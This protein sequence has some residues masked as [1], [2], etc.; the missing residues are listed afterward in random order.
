V[1]KAGGAYLPLDP[2]LPRERLLFMLADAGAPVVLTEKVSL[3]AGTAAEID[4]D[5]FDWLAPMEGRSAGSDCDLDS[6]SYVIYTSG[7]T[8]RPKG[9][10][11]PHRTL[12]NLI[13]WQIERLAGSGVD[14]CLRTLLFASPSFDVSLEETLAT[15]CTGA[16]LVVGPEEARR[17]PRLLVEVLEREGIERIFLPYVALQQLAEHLAGAEANL[18]ILARLREVV[19]AGERLQITPQIA[20]L[21]RRLPGCALRNQ[22][23]PSEAH[24][25]TEQSLLGDPAG[26]PLLPPIGRPIAGVTAYVLDRAGESS[27]LGVSGELALG[28]VSLARG[29]INRPDLTAEK[30]I[31]DPFSRSAGGRLYRTGDLARFQR[32]GEIE[33]LGRIDHQVKI[34]GFRIEPG[35]IEVALAAH[36]QVREAVVVV[37]GDGTAAGRRLVA[38][39]TPMAEE[40]ALAGADLRSFL[41]ERLPEYMLPAAFVVLSALPL[42]ASGKVQ[43]SALPAP[44]DSGGAAAPY[45]P[46]ATALERMVAEV[47]AEQLGAPRVGRDEN[48]FDAGAHSLLLVRVAAELARRLDRKVAVVDLFRFPTVSALARHLGEGA[49]D[50]AP[51]DRAVFER[52]AAERTAARREKR[53]QIRRDEM[54]NDPVMTATMK[55]SPVE[56][57]EPEEAFEQ[58]AV[59]G[60]ACRFPGAADPGELWRNVRDGVESITRLSDEELAA[61]GVPAELIDNPAYVKAGGFLADPD[62]FDADFFGFTPREAEL[63]DPQHRLFLECAWQACEDAGYVPQTYPGRIGVYGGS[64][65]GTYFVNNLLSNPE[66]LAAAGG[67]QVKLFNDKDFLTTHVSYKLNLRG[68]SLAIQTACSTSL[69]AVHVACQALLDGECDM[70]LAGGTGISFPHLAGHLYQEGGISSPDGHCRAFDIRAQGLVDGN[71]T[72]MVLLKRLSR[73]LA[74]GDF[75]HAVVRGSAIN[76]DGAQKAGYTVPSVDSQMEVIG[77]ALAAARVDA[78]TIGLVE[79]HGSGTPIGDPIEVQALTRAFRA[80]TDR[81]GFCALGSIKTNI[82]HT[83]AAAGVAGLIKAV[84]ALEHRQLPPSLHFEVPNPA[85][86]LPE[87]P[88]FVTSRALDWPAGSGQARRRAGVSSLGIGGTN[89]H[90][91]L[92]EAP[93]AALAAPSRPWQLLVVSARSKTA[94]DQAAA[95]LSNHLA[96]STVSRFELA[97]VAHTLRVG[98]KAFQHRRALLCRDRTGAVAAL[99]GSDPARWID[100]TAPVSG[101]RPVAF[102]FPGLGEHYAGMAA[103]LYRG[104]P[105]FRAAIDRSA[106]IL[107]PHLGADLRELLLYWEGGYPAFERAPGGAAAELNLRRMLA[108]EAEEEDEASRQLGRTAFAH[109]AVFA[110]EHALA[111][112]WLAWGIRPRAMIGYSLGEYV[113]AC[114][115]GVFSL[116]DAL[117]LVA[118][119]ARLIDALPAGAMLAVPLAVPETEALLAEEPGLALAAA[120][121]PGLSVVA[122]PEAAAAAFAQRLAGRGIACRRLRTGH[123]FHSPM[124]RPAAAELTR[125]AAGLDLRPPRI[126]FVSNVTGTWITDREATDPAY[127]AEHLCRPVRFASGLETLTADRVGDGDEAAQ[128]LLEVG[129]GQTLGTLAR[130]RPG[131]PAG[132]VVV[133]A[134]RDRREEVSD[135]ASLLDALARLWAAGAEPDWTAFT[136]GERRRR[137]PLPTYPFERRRYFIA[138]GKPAARSETRRKEDRRALGDWFYAPVWEQAPPEPEAAERSP[139]HWLLLGDGRGLAARL[140]DRLTAGGETVQWVT[141]PEDYRSLLARSPQRIVHLLSLT[142]TEPEAAEENGFYSLLALAQALSEMTPENRAGLRVGVVTSGVAAVLGDEALVPERAALLGPCRVLPQELP[143]VTSTVIDL[144]ESDPVDRLTDRLVDRLV[145]RLIA[146]LVLDRPEPLVA[147]RGR[148]RFL[149]RFRPVELPAAGR[150]AARLRPGGVYLI[151]GGLDETGVVLAEQL[152][153]ACGAR[154]ALLAP[155]DTPP[156]SRWG[157]WLSALDER[158]EESRR[159]RRVLALERSGCELLVTAADL[160]HPS[161]VRQAVELVRG[162]FGA[163]H[164]VVHAAGRAGAGLMQW[165]TRSQAA[166]VLAPKTRGTRA[167]AAALAGLPLDFF[168][169]FGTNAASTGGFGQADTA[170]GGA[171]LDTFA[172]AA[173]ADPAGGFPVQAV[174]WGFFRWQPVTASVPEVAAALEEGLALYGIT[175]SEMFETFLR[176]LASPLPQITVA[177]Q[178]LDAVTAQLDSFSATALLDQVGAQAGAQVAAHARPELPVAYEPPRGEVEETVARVWQE[179]FGIDR[180]GRDDNFFD[181]SGNSLLAI[182]I[183]T[184]ISQALE[185]DVAT[186]SLLEA[187]TVARLAAAIE[188]L[189]PEASLSPEEELAAAD[190]EE[191]ERLLL[192]IESL[193]LTEAEDKLARELEAMS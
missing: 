147:L 104:E 25:V 165:K 98:R 166:S 31:P 152:Y 107:A 151:T 129:P 155:E 73:A 5:T 46:P 133:A 92:E 21:F 62:L 101:A 50:D 100:G 158:S 173:E 183:V 93:P 43:R 139:L 65:S 14:P 58:I 122:G 124:M 105:V 20:A 94:L 109:P 2:A 187:P 146:E 61:A 161:Q 54:V 193:S 159:L 174:D 191:L 88:F 106:E 22:Y 102:L 163:L 16:T 186:A 126:P 64:A 168:V 68:P 39:V 167:L 37:R 150:G 57:R 91:V 149:R 182:Q 42:T 82:G 154:L 86:D 144:L 6:T 24:V 45:I 41:R 141:N 17:D 71:G 10:A 172:Q 81:K 162:R 128:L 116:E 79:A 117:A 80:T 180:I 84:A 192:E 33:F 23:G 19:T 185:I 177:T 85:L 118:G 103:G 157:E 96:E 90:V 67:M 60:M 115:A 114:L 87:S 3:P 1:L 27:P 140:A 190:P 74:D 12:A 121:G 70:A 95:R 77:E 7:S 136:S 153:A 179:A 189:R 78:D 119:R 132:E 137:R 75:I 160:T 131:R 175:E 52:R 130:Q 176:V 170:A 69:V 169:L 28:G 72:G 47:V 188:G 181:L 178:D 135:Q 8:G 49:A 48:F 55:T 99:S 11:L 83:D 156:L 111:E 120:N 34:R 66:I 184:R 26:W 164:G 32:G 4:L 15:W 29:Y 51:P 110:V 53:L 38:Y 138:P 127:W 59:I 113:A 145:D 143:G 18:V 142:E 36:P 89:A 13:G 63:M 125:L 123:A 40:S 76:N 97:D 134:L 30:F 112:L 9:I 56:E 44:E 108:P 171:F 148:R 35:E